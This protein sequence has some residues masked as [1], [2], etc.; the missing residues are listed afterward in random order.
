MVL[1]LLISLFETRWILL[2]KLL[3]ISTDLVF[4]QA[5]ILV[6]FFKR[7]SRFFFLS[8]FPSFFFLISLFPAHKHFKIEACMNDLK[9]GVCA[10]HLT[11]QFMLVVFSLNLADPS[12]RCLLCAYV[13]VFP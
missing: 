4:M 6:I 1:I 13:V 2:L 8:F 12:L 10:I 3:I 9:Y 7:E 11:C 5:F